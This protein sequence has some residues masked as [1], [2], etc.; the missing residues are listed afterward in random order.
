MAKKQPVMVT[1]KYNKNVV[2]L[3]DLEIDKT[4]KTKADL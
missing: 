2:Y 4:A 1:Y 3:E